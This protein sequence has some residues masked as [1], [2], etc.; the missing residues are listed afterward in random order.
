MFK[1]E[2]NKIHL[3]R[4]DIALIEVTAKNDDD[5]D[6]AFKKDEVVRLN[7]FK[8]KDCSTVL[9]TKDVTVEKESTT[10]NIFLTNEDTTIGDLINNPKTFWYEIVL[11][12]ETNEQTIVGYDLDGAKEFVLYPEAK[13]N[14]IS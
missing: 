12:P 13:E 7:V 14:D 1:I 9:L 3:T 6:Y 11:N 2:N 10:V 4:G 5:S 8:N